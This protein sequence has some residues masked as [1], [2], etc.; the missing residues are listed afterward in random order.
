[1][2]VGLSQQLLAPKNSMIKRYF[3]PNVSLNGVQSISKNYEVGFRIS[4]SYRAPNIHELFANGLSEDAFRY[5]IGNSSFREESLSQI[6]I[7]FMGKGNSQQIQFALFAGNL[8]NYISLNSTDKFILGAPVF[9]YRS[10]NGNMI[11]G[12]LSYS[13][14]NAEKTIVLQNTL[15]YCQIKSGGQNIAFAPPLKLKTNFIYTIHNKNQFLNAL[16]I[17]IEYIYVK[18]IQPY[19]EIDKTENA[20]HL[21]NFY[22]TKNFKKSDISF[23]TKNCLSSN[24]V[25]PMSMLKSIP[26]TAPG[27]N[28]GLFFKYHF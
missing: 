17:N 26:Y 23:Y 28:I 3:A 5:D 16:K 11:G 2:Q 4:K 20:Y 22:I 7:H 18:V 24:Y 10:D 27:L 14:F 21:F 19:F 6:D 13:L 15:N 9:E 12:E 1:M 25:D 8:N